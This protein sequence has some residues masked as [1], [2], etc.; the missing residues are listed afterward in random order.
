MPTHI[1]MPSINISFNIATI[2]H[3]CGNTVI[4][5][6]QCILMWPLHHHTMAHMR[7]VKPRVGVRGSKN[8][9]TMVQD[10]PYT[11][12]ELSPSKNRAKRGLFFTTFS[13]FVLV[14]GDPISLKQVSTSISHSFP[15]GQG[16]HHFLSQDCSRPLS[17]PLPRAPSSPV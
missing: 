7:R 2:L 5:L 1:I 6:L 8:S 10:E 13:I 9:K 3:V 11:S 16:I 4:I 17:W 12:P 14:S 15:A